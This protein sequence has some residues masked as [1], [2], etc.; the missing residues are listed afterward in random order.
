MEKKEDDKF[1]TICICGVFRIQRNKKTNSV[2]Q[3][4]LYDEWKKRKELPVFISLFWSPSDSFRMND[5]LDEAVKHV[6]KYVTSNGYRIHCESQLFRVRN[7]RT[8]DTYF[9]ETMFPD[10]VKNC[11]AGSLCNELGFKNVICS[12]ETR[13]TRQKWNNLYKE[14][15]QKITQRA[16]KFISIETRT[17][18]SKLLSKHIWLMIDKPTFSYFAKS[19]YCSMTHD[20]LIHSSFAKYINFSR[21]ITFTK[22]VDFGGL[23]PMVSLL[24]ET[25]DSRKFILKGKTRE[26]YDLLPVKQ[27]TYGDFKSLRHSAFSLTTSFKKRFLNHHHHLIPLAVKFIRN[28]LVKCYP[29]KV[30]NQTLIFF[31]RIFYDYFD[32][33]VVTQ[34][35]QEDALRICNKWLEYHQDMFKNIGYRGQEQRWETEANHLSH[36][37]DWYVR[38]EP[39][40]HKNQTWS[41]FWRL[42]QEWTRRLRNDN[43]WDGEL[44]V[45]IPEWQ[46]TGVN[47]K[48]IY[49]DVNEITTFKDLCREGGEMEHCIASYADLCASGR[50][51]AFSVL[52][53]NERATLG[54]SRIEQ[55]ILYRFDQMRGINNEAVSRSMLIKGKK[56]LKEVNHLIAK[57]RT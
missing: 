46:G 49:S 4:I 13:H 7:W 2:T 8:L 32:G 10:E 23:W 52:H 57:K 33:E 17:A 45:A 15:Q 53:N 29:V 38:S 55:T 28:P 9:I 3:W 19:C 31:E 6:L 18:A 43:E 30:I 20:A 47:W 22:G 36:A 24:T 14:V 26:L 5:W 40:I 37:L 34:Q 56:I 42:S 50:Y 48:E 25:K 11:F 51:L 12:E 54:L 1:I 41:S 21:K 39:A 35:N 27:L 16:W 44:N